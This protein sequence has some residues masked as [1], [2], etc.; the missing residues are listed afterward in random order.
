MHS[1]CTAI[2]CR[3]QHTARNRC[4]GSGFLKQSYRQ[5][6]AYEQ[7]AKRGAVEIVGRSLPA[8]Q[9]Q[10]SLLSTLELCSSPC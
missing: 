2:V 8:R 10:L 6:T 9:Q 5:R 4:D 1:R 3:P 7:L